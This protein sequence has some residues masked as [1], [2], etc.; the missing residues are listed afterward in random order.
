MLSVSAKESPIPVS[1]KLRLS[2]SCVPTP[3]DRELHRE[4]VRPSLLKALL[5][6]EPQTIALYLRLY[7]SLNL[8]LSLFT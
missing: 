3:A 6:L 4:R 5:V 7:M 8:R 1:L 2:L